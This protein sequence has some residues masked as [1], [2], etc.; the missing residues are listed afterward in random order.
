MKTIASGKFVMLC[1]DC[2]LFDSYAP[3]HPY[4]NAI[5]ISRTEKQIRA[6]EKY[7]EKLGIKLAPIKED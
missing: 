3:L 5:I 1:I 6:V 7:A 2:I 4:R